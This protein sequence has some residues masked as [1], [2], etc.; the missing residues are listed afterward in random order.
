MYA[1]LTDSENDFS[2]CSCTG[3]VTDCIAI[4]SFVAFSKTVIIFKHI[5]F[6]YSRQCTCVYMHVCM[7][8][9]YMCRPMY[10]R[11]H[12]YIIYACMYISYVRLYKSLSWQKDFR[13]LA[14]TLGTT[15]SIYSCR[16]IDRRSSIRFIRYELTIEIVLLFLLLTQLQLKPGYLKYDRL[17][18]NS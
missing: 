10:V 9:A 5:Y 11:I 15:F 3:S 7:Y 6:M 14:T 12:V 18:I 2:R 17:C 8:V 16:N 1:S 13:T 4:S